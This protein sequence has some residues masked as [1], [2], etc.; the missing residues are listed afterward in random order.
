MAVLMLFKDG[1]EDDL[2][3]WREDRQMDE[4]TEPLPELSFMVFLSILSVDSTL[5]VQ[6]YRVFFINGPKVLAY[7]S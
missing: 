6:K 5:R 2:K 3:T 7:Y 4:W 1:L